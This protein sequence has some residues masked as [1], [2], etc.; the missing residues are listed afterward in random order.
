MMM[1]ANIPHRAYISAFVS[2]FWLNPEP[3]L[4][5]LFLHILHTQ[6]YKAFLILDLD[7][8]IIGPLM[9]LYGK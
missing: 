9:T 6:N 2:Y 1:T 3:I 4:V 8:E 7:I 5:E